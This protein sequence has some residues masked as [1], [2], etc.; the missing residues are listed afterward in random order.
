M[1]VPLA[2]SAVVHPPVIWGQETGLF[3][4]SLAFKHSTRLR[5]CE[6]LLG[7]GQGKAPFGHTGRWYEA[8][9]VLANTATEG[10]VQVKVLSGF[11]RF[12]P[13]FFIIS[14]GLQS[15][16][17]GT[18]HERAATHQ[19]PNLHNPGA[20]LRMCNSVSMLAVPGC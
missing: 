4:H 16:K 9:G 7:A 5:T 17:R 6:I 12:C 1:Y 20:N 2:R 10:T 11:H 8:D 19:T 14:R 13:N 18:Q 3:R 15:S